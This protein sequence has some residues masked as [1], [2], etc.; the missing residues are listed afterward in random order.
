VTRPDSVSSP[1]FAI[2][3]QNPTAAPGVCGICGGTDSVALLWTVG[4][5][6]TEGAKIP[7]FAACR[8][9]RLELGNLLRRFDRPR[10]RLNKRHAAALVFLAQNPAGRAARADVA[11]AA[12][13]YA[14]NTIASLLERGYLLELAPDV[15]GRLLELSAAG[16]AE[17]PTAAA[18]L[19]AYG[20][21]GEQLHASAAV[22]ASVVCRHCGN[23]PAAHPVRVEGKSGRLYRCESFEPGGGDGTGGV[24]ASAE[25]SNNAGALEQLATFQRARRAAGL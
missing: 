7:Y 14:T 10:R 25:Y 18:Y 15:G 5:E 12:G 3:G 2:R 4:P 13:K 8:S 9:C 23:L 20:D 6:L 16:W 19:Q 11:A 1:H 24:H 21:A 17:L 22:A